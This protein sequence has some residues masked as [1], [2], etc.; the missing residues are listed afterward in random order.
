[1]PAAI[2]VVAGYFVGEAVAIG[3]ADVI[4]AGI[5]SSLVGK[6]AGALAGN[7]IGG[8]LGGG[9]GAPDTP[10]QSFEQ[11]TRGALVNTA[12]T[13]DPIPVIYGQRRVGG[14]RVLTEVSGSANGYLHIVL[15]L[16]E[17]Q[18]SAIRN[19][20]LD[21]VLS[22]DSRFSGL[23][24]IEKYLGSDSQAAS[25]ALIADLPAKWTINHRLQG[26]AY[27]YLKLQWNQNA[28]PN[29][30]P[31]ITA[32][33]DGKLVYDPRDAQTKF[34]H[35]PALCVR[36]YLTN[37]R[38]GRSI[39]SAS[40][41]DTLCSSSAN[42][43]EERVSVPTRNITFTA[44]AT[45]DTLSVVDPLF[46]TGHGVQVAVSGGSLPTGLAAATTYY[47]I[48]NDD[49]SI[50][51][52]TSYANAL[53]RTA[54]DLTSAGSG[55]LTLSHI[56]MPR[57]T[58]DGIVNV[59][60]G[61]L[62]NLQGM[63]SSCRGFLVFSG[64]K[65]K[66]QNDKTTTPTAFVFNEDNIVGGWQIAL[67]SKCNKF[68]RVS[69]RFF[70]PANRWQADLGVFDSNS[71]RSS[72]NSI[73][74][75]QNITLN[76]TAHTY[77]A[78]IIA[79]MAEKQSRFPGVV[80]FRA[81]I[82]GLQCEVGDVVPITHST[83]G[84][85]LK[86]FRIQR[87]EL[88]SNDEVQI[89][90]TEY[91]TSVYSLSAATLPDLHTAS[92]L[93]NVN[94][95]A[96]PGTPTVV[97]SLY[98]T[99]GSAG[100][101]SRA[102]ISWAAA[103]DAF[104]TQYQVEYKNNASSAWIV[105]GIVRA[106]TINGDDLGPG[107]FDFRVKS[108][109]ALGV[110]SAY[111]ATTTVTLFGLT[112]PPSD[113]TA[114]TVNKSAGF[115]LA[116]WGECPDLDVQINGSVVIRHNPNTS[117]VTWNNSIIVGTFAGDAIQGFVPLATGTYLIKFIDSSGNYSTNAASFVATEG[118]VNG[119]T[120]VATLTESP[121]FAG[122]K[123]NVAVVSSAIQL[124]SV[125]TID[126]MAALMDS[127]PFIDSLGGI[128][129]SGTYSFTTYMDHATVGTRR[130]EADVRA[131]AFDTGDLI[132]SRTSLIDD[133]DSIDGNVVNDANA[134]LSYSLTNDDPAGSPSWGPW[135]PFLVADVTCRA[136]R[137]KLD[138][139]SASPTH[140]ISIDLLKVDAKT[141]VSA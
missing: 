90:A 67:G 46:G 105:L 93:P 6:A 127:W 91:D 121:T 104:V 59:D 88:M 80:Q 106:L 56:D 47:V 50:Q 13:V 15:V 111:S 96:V 48:R 45:A 51:L 19:V 33:I 69:A 53:A 135:V 27:L 138:L 95:P 115:A 68:N 34:H 101:K 61:T 9:G 131:S 42:H 49:N 92:T 89:T 79:Q 28:F 65:Y 30:L 70:N 86:N 23:V 124:D 78:Q 26:I 130:L 136:E 133:W 16:C 132:D 52:A 97:E 123:S 117:A 58:C 55:T 100:V 54:I 7:L 134:I 41:D 1:M 2:G 81:T 119:Y 12:S 137:Y 85:T 37:T 118:L 43:N 107:L 108:I 62:S 31:T 87:I 44:D 32:D 109:N 57:Y 20:Y 102:T 60:D 84:W 99:T 75:Q 35:N 141:P 14:T 112:A 83:P 18:I 125:S 77:I 116:Q 73:L 129:G 71:D 25:A 110:M 66:I 40:I 98:S 103:A 8:A 29:G 76:F 140:N 139:V 5:V 72:D 21:D 64:G 22:T 38:Y 82:A 63:L 113:P 74:L 128:S 24:T 126:S 3:V 120:T 114:F 10:A 17:G 39:P 11:Q 36:E 94:Q 122:T 4:G